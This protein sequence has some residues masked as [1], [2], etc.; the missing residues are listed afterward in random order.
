MSDLHATLARPALDFFFHG[1]A[2]G[3]NIP[4]IYNRSKFITY[5]LHGHGLMELLPKLAQAKVIILC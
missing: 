5:K 1:P 2:Q 4:Q 3:M